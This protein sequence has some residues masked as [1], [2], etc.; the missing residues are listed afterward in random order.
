MPCREHWLQLQQRKAELEELGVKVYIVTF[1]DNSLA[2]RYVEENAPDW[3][4]LLDPG[5]TV[6]R[7][8]GMGRANW[9]TLAKPSTLWKYFVMW[10][11]GTKPQKVGSDVHQLGGDVLVDP[12]GVL[13]LDYVSKEPHDR[14]DIDT[15]IEIVRGA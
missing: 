1:D 5:R 14:P 15:I 9:W 13:R 4:L 2:R 3:P 7:R 10:C 8:F 6:Y 12:E 11:K